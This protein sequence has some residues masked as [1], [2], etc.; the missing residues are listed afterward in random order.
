MVVVDEDVFAVLVD[1]QA[2]QSQAGDLADATAGGLQEQV[3]EYRHV[4]G[5]FTER[6]EGWPDEPVGVSTVV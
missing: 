6:A 4:A 5:S 1:A 2:I 3:G